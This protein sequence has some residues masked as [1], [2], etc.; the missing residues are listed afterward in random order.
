MADQGA[1]AYAQPVRIARLHAAA[2]G[3]AV[4]LAY[5]VA[6]QIGFRL[7]FLAE[8][9]TTVWAPTGIAL[10]TL[11]LG[12]IRFWPAIWIGALLANATTAA[13]LWTAF[14]IAS[15]NTLEAVL[16]VWGLR[17]VAGFTVTLSRVADVVRFL[18]AAVACTAVSATIGVSTL[19][20]ARVQSWD[21][22]GP[23]WFEWWFGDVLGAVIVAPAILTTIRHQWSVPDVFRAAIF[24]TGS[25]LVTHLVFGELLNLRTYPL[26]YAIFPV[27]IGAAATGELAVTALVVLSASGVA[28]WHTAHGAGLFAGQNA[29]DNLILL[30]VFMGVLAATAL[31]LGAAIAERRAGERRERDAATMLRLAQRAGGVATFEWDFRCQVAQCSAEFFRIFG[32]PAR[33]GVMTGAEWGR[34][35]HPEDRDV[36]AA[37]LARALD[38]HEPAAADYRVVLGDGSIRWLSYAGQFQRTPDGDRMLGTVVDISHRKRLETELR[39]HAAEVERILESI[40]EGFVAFDR[41]LRYIYVNQPA[42]RMLGRP[43]ADLIGQR[44]WDVFPP[45]T[46]RTSRQM[47]EA[48][49]ESGT[50]T[51]YEVHVPGWNRWFENRAYPSEAGLSLFF[52]DVTA[53]VAAE[54][55][56]RES[57]DVLS[58]AMRGGSMGAWS[59]D[60][61][62]N[63]VWWSRELEEIFGLP[64]GGF[65]RTEAGFFDFVHPDDRP[66]VRH[67]VDDAVQNRTDYLVEFRFR[68]QQGDWRWMEGRG[69][70]VYGDDG[71]PR[72]LYGI[73]IDITARKRAELALQQAKAAA[74]EGQLRLAETNRELARE[75]EVRTTLAQVGASI[76]GQ[77]HSE[78]LIQVVTD[79][80][81]KLTEA[82]FG[83]FFFNVTDERGDSYLLS[84]LA[85]APKEA[86]SSFPHPRATQILGPTFRGKMII[87]LDDVTRDPRYGQ[88][89]PFHGMPEGH[90]PVRSYLAV[91]VIGRG[92][93]LL[94]GL[95]FGHSQPG[96]FTN[97]HEL[98]AAGVASWAAIALDNA[99]LYQEAAEA[100]R[101]KDEFLATLSHELRTPLNA[102]L[103]WAH[104]LRHSTMQPSMRERALESVERNAKAQAQL[105]EDLLDVSRIVAGKLQMKSDPVDLGAVIANA[106]DT[107]RAGVTAKRLSLHVHAPPEQR[108]MVSG[109]ADRLQQVVWNLVSNAV[110]FTPAGGR[111]DIELRRAESKAEIVVRDTGQGIAPSFRPYLFQRFRQMD[112]SKTRQHGGLG[113]GLSIVKHLVEAHG[114]AVTAESEGPGHG[115]TFRL[116]LPLREAESPLAVTRT[117]ADR[118]LA[119]VRVLVVDDEAD[120]RELTRY[121]LE[122]RGALAVGTASAGEALHLLASQQ[123]DLLIADIGMP[124]R[125]GLALI[126]ALRSLPDGSLNREVPAI[127]LTAY[128]GVRDRDE[129]LAAGFNAHLGKPID[130][131]QLILTIATFVGRTDSKT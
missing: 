106:V 93:V 7:A 121:V 129:A 22:F 8:Q 74:E 131:D 99:R 108:L 6:A 61:S 54:S 70:A 43:R 80:S 122:G 128:T 116:Q 5:F 9:I 60:I 46:V 2:L 24:V 69:R 127:A 28:I 66:L 64:P 18:A 25:V 110:K 120:A 16:A 4:G 38:G 75:V 45:E 21:T 10:A 40:G 83:A 17:R 115:A 101:L 49:I 90:L 102:V 63:A 19:S 124:E 20:A 109:D 86:F 12:G 29:H 111:V 92:D 67:V 105:V 117:V 42:E 47:L 103:G 37:H 72:T 71:A 126:R 26:E 48:A 76:A 44:P 51:S 55:A 78:K 52:T 118:I 79:A 30:Q 14:L 96:V 81:T 33:D 84:S 130:P 125:D 65:D 36:M 88:N 53:R 27:V 98:L 114:G 58:L 39:H 112:A 87:R 104:M 1:A 35:V 56:L 73:G 59:R 113:L 91:P 100:N 50:A 119:G 97:R 13:P 123:Y 23:L 32:L 94:G 85:G 57:Q 34:F 107:V 82:E 11:L 89:P 62:T 15:G 41:E 68:Q 3:I 31:L 95:L 77:L